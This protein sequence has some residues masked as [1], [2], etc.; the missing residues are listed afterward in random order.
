MTP[1]KKLSLVSITPFGSPVVPDVYSWNATSAPAPAAPGSVGA[2]R[3]EA[4]LRSRA[5]GRDRRSRRS[6]RPTRVSGS[7]FSM[8]GT[9]SG[10]TMTTL[11][12]A[13]SM[14]CAISVGA[15]RQ[16]TATFTALS[17]ASANVVSKYSMPFL[18]R[19]ATRS[20][21]HDTGGRQ[22]VRQPARTRVELA[23]CQRAAVELDR[24]LVRAVPAVRPDDSRDRR[25]RHGPPSI[26]CAAPRPS[27]IFARTV[28]VRHV[29][30]S[31]PDVDEV[32]AKELALL[33]PDIRADATEVAGLL[34]DDFREF[35]ASGRVWDRQSVAKALA[36]EPGDGG[37]AHD[38]DAVRLAD[39]VVLLTYATGPP[40]RT[41]LRSSLWVRDGGTWRILFHQGTP[42]PSKNPAARAACDP[43]R[44]AGAQRDDV[45]RPEPR[46]D[47]DGR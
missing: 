21:A 45:H 18:S 23:E 42:S 33:R 29:S 22:R 26:W 17:F 43:V 28:Y 31:D 25:D 5:S 40:A 46:G 34:H 20:P 16:L 7:I 12:P 11:A 9:N 10:P 19:N 6:S 14:I 3:R 35:G 27:E 1:L 13:S 30:G 4:A 37:E 2:L 39:N 8:C 36:A 15:S 47:R 44:C 32:V 24:R 38:L 41:A